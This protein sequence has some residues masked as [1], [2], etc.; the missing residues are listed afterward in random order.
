MSTTI[1]NGYGILPTLIANSTSI[2][3]QLDT[4]TEQASTG[5]VSQTYAGLGGEASVSLDLNPQLSALQTYQ[6]NI[7]QATGSMQVTQTAMTQIQQIAATF[8]GDIPNLNGLNPSEIDSIASQA[9]AALQQVAGLLDTQDGSNYVFG[10]QD[11][12][13]P[14]V[15]SP[16][17]ILSSGFYTQINAS[18]SALS[19]NGASATAAATLATASSNAIGT[20]PFSAYMSQ[21]AS[22]ISAPV[23]QTGEG[24]TVQIGLLASGNSVAVSSGTSTTGSYMRDLMRALATLGSLSSSQVSD[25]GFSG[26][27]QDTAASLNGVVDAMAVDAGIL[28]STQSSLT[29]TQTHLSNTAT[30]LTG[31]LS[32]VQQV[33]M[34]QTLSDLTSMQTQLQASYRLISSDTGLSLVNFLPASS[35]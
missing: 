18:V 32:S 25:P 20:S 3:Q 12:A 35:G 33:N 14:P 6:N 23:V 1:S 28:G 10:G 19:T 11:S 22:A 2:H 9:K 34:A 5:L 15:P 16:D 30:A 24:G 8:A 13:N 29:A 7:D 4:L 26:L 31:Q 17:N 21:P 27:V